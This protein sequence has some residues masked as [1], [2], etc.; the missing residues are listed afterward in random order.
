MSRCATS[1]DSFEAE[2]TYMIL[3]YVLVR[4]SFDS[5]LF[6]TASVLWGASYWNSTRAQEDLIHV[7]RSGS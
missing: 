7:A 6:L 5:V 1:L 4:I 3:Y 2:V